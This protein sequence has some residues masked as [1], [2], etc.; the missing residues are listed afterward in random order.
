MSLPFETLR[1]R[2]EADIA[3][4]LD[5]NKPQIRRPSW[6]PPLVLSGELLEICIKLEL[7]ISEEKPIARLWGRFANPKKVGRVLR[8]TNRDRDNAMAG[9]SCRGFELYAGAERGTRSTLLFEARRWGD[10]CWHAGPGWLSPTRDPSSLVYRAQREV[11]SAQV[12]VDK[13]AE[14]PEWE[15]PYQYYVNL[16]ADAERKLATEEAKEQLRFQRATERC[17]WR[18]RATELAAARVAE[19]AGN[20][21]VQMRFAGRL[22]GHCSECF[23]ALT[24]PK[25]LEIGIGPECVQKV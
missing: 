16:V 7:P 4:R 10:G 24:D 18:R 2:A 13:Y 5:P 6:A 23:R 22:C 20:Q 1:L 8:E 19:F 9:I 11:D 3:A 14:H 21:D 15:A 12:W 17:Q 25:S